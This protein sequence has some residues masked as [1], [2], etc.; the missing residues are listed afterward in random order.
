MRIK[1][2]EGTQAGN[3]FD[4]NTC[5]LVSNAL[6]GK[7]QEQNNGRGRKDGCVLVGSKSHQGNEVYNDI[8][9][10]LKDSEI[11][12]RHFLI[13]YDITTQEYYLRDLGDG[14][15]TFVRLDNALQLKTG[16]IISFGDSHMF[17]QITEDFNSDISKLEIQF[18]DGPKTDEKYSFS[19][20]KIQNLYNFS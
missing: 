2:L 7:A 20:L 13:K 6:N 18:L 14:N 11:S 8:V 16:F 4:I 15:G 5:G 12:N 10:D 3:S 1:V 19:M 17:M 9:L